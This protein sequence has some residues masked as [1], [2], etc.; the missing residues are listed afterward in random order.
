MIVYFSAKGMLVAPSVRGL[1]I[2]T[3]SLK[4]ASD[5]SLKL[6]EAK[7]FSPID[8]TTDYTCEDAGRK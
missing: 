5:T 4:H 3:K 8:Y 6:R 7:A 1:G 2:D